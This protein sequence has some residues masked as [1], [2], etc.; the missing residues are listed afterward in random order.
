MNTFSRFSLFCVRVAFASLG[1]FPSVSAQK[2]AITPPSQQPRCF[3]GVNVTPNDDSAEQRSSTS[4]S[5]FAVR[6][7]NN[8]TTAPTISDGVFREYR[9]AV[10]MTNEGFRSEQLNQDVSKVKAFWKELETFL[11][12]IYV[13]DL[14]V[15]FTIVQDERLIE[16]S[17]KGSY[18]YD[19]GTKLIN[20]AIGSDAYDIGIVVNYIEGGALQGL[21]SPG[22]VKFQDRK[23]WAIV[24]SQEMITIGHELGH[25]F[26]ADHP[27]VGGA[28]LV[29]RCT[30]PK[31]GQSMM[32]Y[33]Y[34]YKEDFI[35]LESLRMMQPVTKESDYKLPATAKHTTPTNTAPRIDRSKMRA[36]YRVPKGTFFTIPVYATDAEQSSLLY[37]FNQFG[38]HSGNPATFPVFPPQHDAKLSF[39]RRYGGASMIANSDEIPV[40]NYR[41]WLSVS[42]AL[43]VEEAIAK[44]QAP[45][46]DGYI[47][48]VKVVNATPFK[49]TSNIASQYA[50][51]QKLTL[52][53]S[54]D[55]TFFKEGSKVRV[56]MSDDFGETFSHVLVPSTANDGE[57][58]V[59]LPQKL[60]EKFSTYFNIWFAGKGL[61]RLETID[62]DFQYYDLS[63]NALVDGGIEVVKSPVTFEGLPTNNY[64]KLAADAPLP[65]A[66]QVTAKV[67]NAPVVPSFSE[68]TE[69]NMTIRTWRVQQGGEVYGGQQF[70]EREAAETPEIPETPKD[71][72]VQQITLTP[73]ASSVV[74]GESL[75]ITAKVLPENATNTTLK[76]KITPENIL[77]PTAA[78]GQFT[79][80]QVGEALVRAE[81]VDGSGITAECKV[82][83]KPR[84]V[85]AISLNA[86]QKHLIVGDAFSLTATL[87]PENATNRNVIWK[88]VSGD[89]ISLSNTGVIQAKKVG[90]ALV[91]AEAEDGSGI[92]AE[93]KVVVKPRLVQAISLNAT[94]KHLIVGDAFSLT[95]TLSPENATNRNVIWKLV[96]GDAISLS[97][98]GIVQAKKVGEALV[99]AEAADGSGVSAECKVVV[100]PRLVQ[101]ISLNATQKH[102]VVGDSFTLTATLS[103]ENATNRN[104][105]WKLVSGNAISLSNTGVIQAKKVGEAIVRAEA[106]D[107]SGITAECKVV[108]KPRLVQAISLKLEKDTVAVGE[109]FMVSADVLP[110]NATNSTLQWS[111]SD[112]LLLKHLGAGSF[113]A[114]KT[115]S[116]TVTAQ[117]R[118]GSKQEAS[119]RIEI[120][121]PT[122]LKKALAADVAPQV[123]VDGNTLVVKQV[124]SGQWLHILDVQGHLLHQVK[125]YGEPLRIVSPQMPQVLLLKVAQ[126][127]YKVLLTQP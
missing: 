88:L 10:Y 106:A 90:E 20:A 63:N 16:K 12:N 57:C 5:A 118:D 8:A 30:E 85:Q 15:R 104:V 86:T 48:K 41:F 25:L 117:A 27:F 39:G 123:S 114:L 36:E 110:K 4:H 22:G 64:L 46:Y 1:L 59:Y 34:P 96:S 47:A 7:V 97:N 2:R 45:L 65:P 70:I 112:P 14:G 83:V 127:S 120:V 50:M 26:G 17:Y 19:A 105:V 92:T 98:T 80:Q 9:L 87:S 113:E 24:N 75:Q 33:G 79:A 58:E 71:V 11:N 124:P 42:D 77:K 37:A 21:A 52:K 40:G 126:R 28:G 122:A 6:G 38:C 43:P 72:K 49:I 95:A 115:G 91:R 32:S 82:V 93:C 51:G 18:A 100:K 54:V 125:S 78:S 99:R 62:D 111:V 121:P 29:G 116:A 23:G 13:R 102:L 66:P 55:K 60:M 53:W 108:V 3:C 68:T 35:S 69:G 31:S 74:V 119:C 56:V 109:H 107:G 94:Q 67:N 44:K 101:A 61:I 76:W 89:A 84:L 81:A 103:P 73:S